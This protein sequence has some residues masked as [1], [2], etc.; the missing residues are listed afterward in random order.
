MPTPNQD[1][2]AHLKLGQATDYP[3]QFDATLLQAVPRQ[4]N[5]D[6]LNIHADNLPF[7]GRDL[8]TCYELSWL[9]PNG[10]PAVV[11]AEVEV[12][13]DS[14]NLIESKSFK[15]YLN[16]YNQ[17]IFA[18]TEVVAKQLQT[19]LSGCANS[20]VA[21]RLYS[22]HEYSQLGI[23]E[24]PGDCI[25]HEP[26][27]I[28]SYDYQPAILQELVNADA[29]HVKESLHSHLLKS[30]CLITNQ[31]DWGSV[32]IQYQGRQI[33]RAALLAYLVSFRNHNEFHEQCVER[34]Y[35]DLQRYGEFSQL[36]VLARYTRRGG[37]DINPMRASAPELLD[38][39][40]QRARLARQ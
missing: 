20:T 5:R 9:Q 7:V 25:D 31:P 29:Q 30:N 35:T 22:L 16:G 18:S 38:P 32:L 11:I 3:T 13:A 6:S 33:N 14:P 36:T 37:L 17:S 39:K 4:M 40:L 34:I 27:D 24:L 10:V 19:D 23:S 12:P 1:T 8:W 28:H 15:L 2:L 26:V 21:V